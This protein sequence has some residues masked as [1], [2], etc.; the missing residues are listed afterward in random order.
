MFRRGKRYTLSAPANL[1]ASG[2]QVTSDAVT[3]A[4]EYQW[5][6]RLGS[7]QSFALFATTSTPTLP[8]A[9]LGGVQGTIQ[10]RSRAKRRRWYS[11]YSGQVSVNLD[12]A[13][14][15]PSAPTGLS[16]TTGGF[17]S[18]DAA[19]AGESVSR[20]MIQ[21]SPAGAGTW[22]DVGMAMFAGDPSWQDPDAPG[23]TG[24]YD[25]RV[26][27][28]NLAGMS[29]W[30][31]TATVTYSAPAPP[32]G[33]IVTA[34]D[35]IYD[36]GQDA[37]VTTTATSDGNWSSGG[38]WSNGVPS[39]SSTAL[40][41]SGR[42]VTMD[43]TNGAAKTVAVKGNL[44]FP[45]GA[46]SKLT[47]THLY[48]YP[49]GYLRVG[50]AGTPVNA[51]NTAEIVI[52]DT[53]LDT[54]SDPRQH[55]NGLVCVDGKVEMHGAVKTTWLRA[56]AEPTAGATTLTLASTPSGWRSGDSL[57][58]HDTDFVDTYTRA[59][60]GTRWKTEFRT[61]S[62]T[63]STATVNLNSALTYNHYG[64]R[65]GASRTTT[66]RYLAVPNLTRN[67]KIYSEN[68]NGT[69][70][71]T[72]F[73]MACD[74]DI[75]YVEFKGLGRSKNVNFNNSTF[76]GTPDN[77]THIGTNQQGRY[78]LHLHHLEGRENIDPQYV[79]QGCSV[80]ELDHVGWP[81]FDADSACAPRWAINL[82]G[83]NWGH[84]T[85]NVVH[86]YCGSG[87]FVGEM[88]T[89]HR[90]V[91]T[92]N[93]VIR[94]LGTGARPD[95]RGLADLGYEGGNIWWRS[96]TNY[97]E[98]NYV[99]EGDFGYMLFIQG[100][101]TVNLPN[102]PGANPNTPADNTPVN[103][104]RASFG[105]F[106]DN[107]AVC[108]NEGFEPWS[109]GMD[110]GFRP[111]DTSD[112][113]TVNGFTVW[114]CTKGIYNYTTCRMQYDGLL[115]IDARSTGF[116][117]GDYSEDGV[118]IV[119]SRFVWCFSGYGAGS[120][121]TN[122]HIW[123]S[124]TVRDTAFEYNYYGVIVSSHYHNS[125][126]PDGWPAAY[127][128]D[129]CTFT[130]YNG[131]DIGYYVGP[132]SNIIM[133]DAAVQKNNLTMQHGVWVTDYNG[134]PGDDFQ[135]YWSADRRDQTFAAQTLRN[136]N[137]VQISGPPEAGL[138]MQQA[139]DKYRVTR[140]GLLPPANGS[141]STRANIQGH[142]GPVRPLFFPLM[143]TNYLLHFWSAYDGLSVGGSD[144]FYDGY[145]FNYATVDGAVGNVKSLGMASWNFAQATAGNKPTYRVSPSR[146]EFDG[147]DYL[148]LYQS[149][150]AAS[151]ALAG[152][153][154]VY[155]VGNQ[156]DDALYAILGST[157]DASGFEI[158]ASDLV[159]VVNSAGTATTGATYTGR[160]TGRRFM[161]FRR[162][163]GTC[164]FAASDL[165]EVSL[166]TLSGTVNLN[167]LGARQ[168][169]GAYVA[170]GQTWEYLLVTGS[171]TPAVGTEDAK[172]RAWVTEFCSIGDL[173]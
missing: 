95:E 93:C 153:F 11:D 92:G 31:A 16:V 163:S 145:P 166:G 142:L 86:N 112:T 161:R 56:A 144:P 21:R 81:K 160:S 108:C 47:V 120:R 126:S 32:T 100:G 58:V 20:W 155:L 13:P 111:P 165:A 42:T 59:A 17:L 83:C 82:H 69:R 130:P 71:H 57:I 98:D 73:T 89:E 5:E 128:V 150:Y 60:Q 40:I 23:L 132:P 19:P 36:W 135:V 72:F 168:N 109:L 124:G 136:V 25:Y 172:V 78:A 37:L 118:E 104:M 2:A 103:L 94:C 123:P 117:T 96:P 7:D 131:A 15:P 143:A 107:E 116:Y 75:R 156:T 151:R 122:P 158:N 22:A 55:G 141:L 34:W 68:P 30:S 169:A 51:A 54:A 88:G 33:Y 167:C 121:P 134:T 52:R 147:G 84:C 119:N 85:D 46:N 67:V 74:V 64:A 3:D 162:A 164:Y 154:T 140:H 49:T 10:L 48:V 79:I 41:P 62:G 159:R 14:V 148:T 149:G 113:L 129:N 28:E 152:D 139:W 65:S 127:L 26:A 50:T 63:P 1:A 27:A 9:G 146:L 35:R 44:F 24:N 101:G 87:I 105:S 157:N 53:A 61:V 137:I 106:D 6:R 170:S 99:A 110:E 173:L 114:G 77:A 90:N 138:T 43:A 97:I 70:G 8:N 38:T 115:V 12:L 133:V 76:S 125:E 45:T 66:E 102:F 91:V 18:W 39:A 4:L 29:A 171:N 80:Y